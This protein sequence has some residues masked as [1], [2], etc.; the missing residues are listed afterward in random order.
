MSATEPRRRP[1][2]RPLGRGDLRLLL[3]SLIGQAP[4]HGYEL[5]QQ[6]SEMFM[7]VYTPS[8]GS[9]YPLLA[10]FENQRWVQAEEE[11]GRKRYHITAV[12][13]AQ[14]K[15]RQG[16]VDDALLRARHSA[17]VITKANL[18]P[19]VREAMRELTHSMMQRHGRWQGANVER[20]TALLDE[21][22]ALVRDTPPE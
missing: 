3:L 17:R 1:S 5:I 7:R 15:L 19:S 6:V 4:R 14:L 8:A 21:A 20:I 13:Q 12:G 18:P 10:D 22:T 11:G 16:E 9:V 2:P